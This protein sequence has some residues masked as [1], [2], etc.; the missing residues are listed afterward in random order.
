MVLS[1]A[2]SHNILFHIFAKEVTLDRNHDIIEVHC[3]NDSTA[4]LVVL[5]ERLDGVLFVK[6]LKKYK[7]AFL[8]KRHSTVGR[9]CSK[10]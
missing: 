6:I 1:L 7:F 2:Y 10:T 9:L 8:T 4:V 3:S 5:L